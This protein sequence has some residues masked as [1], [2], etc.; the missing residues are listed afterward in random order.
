[1]DPH[2][3]TELGS[4][5][6]QGAAGQSLTPYAHRSASAFDQ[7]G[8]GAGLRVGERERAAACDALA[9]HFA[10][11]RLDPAELDD[12]LAR[13]M[14]ARTQ[15]DLRALFVDLGPRRS[16]PDVVPPT[17]PPERAPGGASGAVAVSLLVMSLL[18]AGGMLLVLGAYNPALF[19]AALVGGTATAVGGSC[20]TVLALAAWRRR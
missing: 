15:N 5:P 1:V 19:L 16:V 7:V 4:H 14:A 2:P 11:G 3:W 12:R 10:A 17:H 6:P 13:A 9:E 20:V 18:L 8:P